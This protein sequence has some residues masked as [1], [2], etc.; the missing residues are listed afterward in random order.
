MNCGDNSPVYGDMG[1]PDVGVPDLPPLQD[2]SLGL[3][4]LAPLDGKTT[5][6]DAAPAGCSK[7]HGGPTGPAP[8]LSVTG[9]S[10]TSERGVGAHASH[11]KASTWRAAILCSTCHLV[12]KKMLDKGHI[13][14]ALPAEVMFSAL[15][16]ADGAKPWWTG[17]TCSGSYCHGATL[18][19]GSNTAPVWTKVDGSQAACGSCHGLPPSQNHTSNTQCSI[20]HKGV[21]DAKMK[22]VDLAKHIN[23]KVDL[24]GI[25]ACNACHGSSVNAAP[26]KSVS[27]LT[28][29]TAREVGA[30]QLHLKSSSWRATVSCG[31]CHLVPKTYG[32][33]GHMDGAAPAEVTFSSL[34]TA[35]SA[36]PVWDGTTCKGSYCHGA[37]L[38]KGTNTA[39]S[40]TKVNGTQAACGTCHGLPPAGHA[41]GMSC[42]TCHKDVVDAKM[43]IIDAAKHIDGKVSANGGCTICH[44][45]AQG[46]RRKIVG[47][48]ADFSTTAHHV[49]GTI[50]DASL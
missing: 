21:V 47:S 37:T 40:W 9:K 13:D 36:K 5:T 12:P 48:G 44:A 14:T 32:D 28:S 25:S 50:K 19:G 26:P 33:K 7:C 34:A 3:E 16:K 24:A 2:S 49:K 17:S 39:P 11:L 46:S 4:G 43:K 20:C 1:R 8:P 42:H 22:I 29:P 31:H 41:P 30:H 27:G 45:K 23:G 38:T 15:V 18:S 10:A 6:V 35:N